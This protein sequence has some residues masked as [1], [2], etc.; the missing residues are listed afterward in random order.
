MASND[1]V[2]KWSGGVPGD[3]RDAN[4]RVLATARTDASTLQE[5]RQIAAIAAASVQHGHVGGDALPQQ[6]V[7]QI[8]VDLSELIRQGC[9]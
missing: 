8:D 9:V 5:I 3:R 6:L 2:R 1:S 7:E 4:S